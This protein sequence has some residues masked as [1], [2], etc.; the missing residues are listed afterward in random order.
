M[1][2]FLVRHAE[3]E[4]VRDRWQTPDSKLSE[5][6]K[7]QAKALG[8]QIKS[9][10]IDQIFSSNWERSRNTAE[11]ISKEIKVE[12]KALDYIHEREQL[13]EMYGAQR[14]SNISKKY[15]EEYHHN[16][17]NLDWKFEGKEESVREVINRTSKLLS[18]LKENYQGKRV[19]VVS[20]DI[21][22][23]CL[24]SQVFLGSKY[25]D[26]SIARIIN[27]MV[28]NTS[29]LSLLIHSSQRNAWQVSYINN[30]SHLKYI[31]RKED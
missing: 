8:E 25:A 4:G 21:F 1:F 29:G 16:F 7:E 12:T 3:G 2:L 11:I 27:T 13:Q 26:N 5:F 20:H 10:K 30:Y 15:I 14:D 17:N 9:F 22:L 31:E 24:I 18:F 23:R 6:G 19:L 28:I